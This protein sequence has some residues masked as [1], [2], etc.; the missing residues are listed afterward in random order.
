VETAGKAEGE[1][2]AGGEPFPVDMEAIKRKTDDINMK[3]SIASVAAFFKEFP[4]LTKFINGQKVSEASV[5]L[6]DY[7]ILN[8]CRSVKTWDNILLDENGDELTRVLAVAGKT[9]SG[10]FTK[11]PRSADVKEALEYLKKLGKA[12]KARF[13]LVIDKSKLEYKITLHMPP[14]GFTILGWFDEQ[15]N[16]A[17]TKLKKELEQINAKA[18]ELKKD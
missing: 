17:S 16:L 18:E 14:R 2:V 10:W 5:S 3:I 9:S 7:S 12:Q 15:V 1:H 11:V 6:I 8:F 13:L 4:F